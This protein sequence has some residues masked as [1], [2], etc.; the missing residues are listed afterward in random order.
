MVLSADLAVPRVTHS[1]NIS[2]VELN[3]ITISKELA[4]ASTTEM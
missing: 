2:L 3:F 1:R 4:E